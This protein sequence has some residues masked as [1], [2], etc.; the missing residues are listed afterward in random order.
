MVEP[1]R[2]EEG[3]IWEIR[4]RIQDMDLRV[5]NM[6]EL[7]RGE[8]AEEMRCQVLVVEEVIAINSIPNLDLNSPAIRTTNAS[9]EREISQLDLDPSMIL[10]TKELMVEVNNNSNVE[11]PF[12]ISTRTVRTVD[13]PLLV[14]PRSPI[15]IIKTRMLI[16]VV[17][18]LIE[19]KTK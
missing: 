14:S 18:S 15:S 16:L 1:A 5:S 19:E 9:L 12:P 10:R 7:E 3:L 13:F 4:T 6:E 17:R 11:V 8:L 2:E